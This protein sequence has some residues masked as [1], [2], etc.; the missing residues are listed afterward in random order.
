MKQ[1]K[2]K[3]TKTT[4]DSVNHARLPKGVHLPD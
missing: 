3:I 1:L 2:K 4:R